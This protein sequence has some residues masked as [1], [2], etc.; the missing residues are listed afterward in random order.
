M[1]SGGSSAPSTPGSMGVATPAWDVEKDT[2]ILFRDH[3]VEEI[4]KIEEQTRKDIDS[5]R[6]DLRQMVG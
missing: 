3:G 1:L 5:R 4:K 2:D 6:E